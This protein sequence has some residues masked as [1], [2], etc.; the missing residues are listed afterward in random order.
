M[1]SSWAFRVLAV[2]AA[3]FALGVNVAH[4]EDGPSPAPAPAPNAPAKGA[5]H[6]AVVVGLGEGPQVG[7][8]KQLAREVYRD[9]TLRA[10]IDEP[11]A[12]VLVGE[13]MAEDAPARLK[14]LGALRASTSPSTDDPGARR[15][16]AS[17]GSDVGAEIVVVVS[18]GS[19]HPIARVL[20]VSGAQYEPVE[21]VPVLASE[22]GGQAHWVFPEASTTLR[23]F[24]SLP[25]VPPKTATG[26]IAPTKVDAPP[27][28]L[29]RPL[30]GPSWYKS[31]WFWGPLGA[32]VLA[33]G[34]IFLATQLST[35]NSTTVHVT[36]TVAP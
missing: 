29:K 27:K 30:P 16:L 10:S 17:I 31:P 22:P 28:P 19:E 23:R 21:L 11:F 24:L 5:A 15:I 33:G 7:A 6:G 9:E 13:A 32:V 36:G 12:R 34:A 25:D 2:G 14:E 18:V 4:A 35:T 26:P 20:R 3:W 8:A 1:R